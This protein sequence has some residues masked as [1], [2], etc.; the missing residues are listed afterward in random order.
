MYHIWSNT[1]IHCTT[2]HSIPLTVPSSVD[3]LP[4]TPHCWLLPYIAPHTWRSLPELRLTPP[5]LLPDLASPRHRFG[6]FLDPSRLA[7]QPPLS[8]TSLVPTPTR[9]PSFPI[10]TLTAAPG[11]GF[12][13]PH[14]GSP[15]RPHHDLGSSHHHYLILAIKAPT[16]PEPTTTN[17]TPPS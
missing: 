7:R 14:P 13:P 3:L 12:T 17:P 5:Q 9:A 10:S 11:L 4:A 1:F 16:R 8:P 15:T 2:I 6:S